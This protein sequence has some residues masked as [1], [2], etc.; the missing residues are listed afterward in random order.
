MKV[1]PRLERDV[2]RDASARFFLY[3]RIDSEL[4]EGVL[5]GNHRRV[6]VVGCFCI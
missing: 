4:V 3:R 6:E 2:R 5:V 1:T